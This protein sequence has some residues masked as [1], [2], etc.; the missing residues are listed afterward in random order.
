[1]VY[2][3]NISPQLSIQLLGSEDLTFLC[4]IHFTVVVD[5]KFLTLHDHTL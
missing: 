5:D 1:M 4:S 3:L 2:M